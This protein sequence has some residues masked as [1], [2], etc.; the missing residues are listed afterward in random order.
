MEGPNRFWHGCEL[1]REVTPGDTVRE[2]A[3]GSIW[4]L[5]GRFKLVSFGNE[6]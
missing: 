6:Y 3:F 2:R 4:E 1:V 5:R